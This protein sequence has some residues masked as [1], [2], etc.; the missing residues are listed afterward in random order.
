MSLEIQ[1]IK[2]KPTNQE[3]IVRQSCLRTATEILNKS[4]SIKNNI[5]DTILIAE[6]LENWCWRKK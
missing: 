4:N 1:N 3:L 2:V 6:E 5:E